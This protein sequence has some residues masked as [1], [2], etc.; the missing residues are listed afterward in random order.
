MSKLPWENVK[1]VVELIK[2]ID[3]WANIRL[4]QLIPKKEDKR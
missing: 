2:N 1:E 3:N 4:L